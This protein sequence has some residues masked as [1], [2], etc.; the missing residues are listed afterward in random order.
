MT[1]AYR[2]AAGGRTGL[3]SVVLLAI[4]IVAAAQLVVASRLTAHAAVQD[5]VRQAAGDAAAIERRAA[6]F[7]DNPPAAEAAAADA[8]ATV[9]AL[10]GVRSVR[11]HPAHD[12]S[13]GC[14]VRADDWP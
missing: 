8:M 1:A 4:T 2:P 5:A 12:S 6:A 7:R 3:V 10:P 11:L 9:A 14:A 13:I